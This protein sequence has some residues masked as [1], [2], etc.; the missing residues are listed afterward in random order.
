MNIRY[1]HTVPTTHSAEVHRMA[2]LRVVS[3][4]VERA[5]VGMMTF[6][7]DV[8]YDRTTIPEY[9]RHKGGCR[10]KKTSMT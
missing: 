2:L 1:M 5:A 6:V 7:L 3:G 10:T 9:M 8:S 4:T